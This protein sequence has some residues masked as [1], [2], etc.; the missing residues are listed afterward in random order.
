[1]SVT[2]Y[3]DSSVADVTGYT[4]ISTG[5]IS[6]TSVTISD[7]PSG[8]KDL[9]LYFNDVKIATGDVLSV[10]VNG[11]SGTATYARSYTI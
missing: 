1:M 7:I 11:V 4:L 3:G 10:R 8:Y 5:S 9:A 6:G 2:R